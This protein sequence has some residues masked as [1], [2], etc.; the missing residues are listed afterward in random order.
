[1]HPAKRLVNPVNHKASRKSRKA[2]KR[3][4]RK[5]RKSRK[6]SRKSRKASGNVVPITSIKTNCNKKDYN[7][8]AC[9]T[10][11]CINFIKNGKRQRLVF[12][13]VAD[14]ESYYKKHLKGNKE[15]SKFMRYSIIGTT[16]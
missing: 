13:S 12:R 2:S 7:S 4:S 1:M 14:R 6:A 10:Y 16:R 8:G 9:N 11:Q 15:Y 3:K 5:S